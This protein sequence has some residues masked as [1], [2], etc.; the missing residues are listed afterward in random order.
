[1]VDPNEGEFIVPGK[2]EGYQSKKN[3][4]NKNQ[5]EMSAEERIKKKQKAIFKDY[6]VILSLKSWITVKLALNQPEVV[7][8]V[9]APV[10]EQKAPDKKPGKK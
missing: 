10:V 1:M 7:A 3:K 6:D 9:A 2:V 8:P 5:K 4:E